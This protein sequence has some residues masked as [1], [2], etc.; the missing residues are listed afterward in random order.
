MTA[1][2]RSALGT[3]A[4]WLA[5]V[6]AAAVLST[7]CGPAGTG[8][9]PGTLHVE[10]C[11]VQL[12]DARCGTLTVPEDRADDTGRTI[13]VSFVVLPAT[14]AD[15]SPD[16]LLWMAGGPGDAASDAIPTG[17]SGLMEV[18]VDHDLVF[19]DQRGTG[20]SNPLTCPAFPGMDDEQ[21]LKQGLESCLA[22]LPGDPRFYTTAMFV[23][24]VDQ[25]LEALGYEAADLIGISYGTIA[26]QVMLQRHP[27]RVRSMILLSG[28]PLTVPVY[29]RMSGNAQA[30]L[31][32]VFARCADEPGCRAAFP[33]LA[34]DWRRLGSSLSQAPWVLPAER[35]PTGQELRLDQVTLAGAMN[36]L[37]RSAATAADIPLVVHTLG[38]AAD[39]PR[40]HAGAL[41]SVATAFAAAMQEGGEQNMI[42]YPFMCNEPWAR[43][44]PGALADQRASF[45]YQSDV[46]AARWWEYVC[47]ML[48]PAP[49]TA[50]AD[51]APPASEIP[52]LILNGEADPIDPPSIMADAASLWPNSRRLVGPGQG[53]DIGAATW[54]L[55]LSDLAARFLDQGVDGLDTGC[56]DYV[57]VPPFAL[58]LRSLVLPQ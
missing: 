3:T 31:D 32:S 13:D 28:S 52:V 6:S 30:A 41:A 16:P 49:S 34:G 8:S 40:D 29:E 24:D 19:V 27:E 22:S 38:A 55:C 50:V 56:V 12:R 51:D 33:D 42:S 11:T 46:T 20:G 48:P 15:P 45:E 21:G 54:T 25:L 17:L 5:A 4:R 44:R 37:L 53:H 57:P 2:P 26:E 36:S 9:T 10:A 35:S 47:S 1:H 43:S 14:G 23:D 39:H 18:N 7:S 58:D